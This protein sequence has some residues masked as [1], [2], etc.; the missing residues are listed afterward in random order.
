MVRC[1]L[2]GEVGISVGSLWDVEVEYNFFVGE[3]ITDFSCWVVWVGCL[4]CLVGDLFVFF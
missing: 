3:G 4:D 1:L 2:F